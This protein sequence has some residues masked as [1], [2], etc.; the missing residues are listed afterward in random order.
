VWGDDTDDL[1]M[2]MTS[3]QTPEWGKWIRARLAAHR[4]QRVA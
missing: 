3:I 1:E 4:A 2:F